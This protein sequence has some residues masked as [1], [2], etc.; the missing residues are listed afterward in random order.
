MANG[1]KRSRNQ[2]QNLQFKPGE[3]LPN[4]IQTNLKILFIGINPGLRSAATQHHFAG[5]SNRFWRF[6]AEAQLTPNLYKAEQDA[7]LLELGYG[8]TNIVPRPTAS[9]AEL[10]RTEFETGAVLLRALL[11]QYQPH[12]A[13]Y[14]GKDIYRFVARQK[15]ICWGRQLSSIIEGVIDYVIPNPSGLNRMPFQEQLNWYLELKKMIQ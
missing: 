1:T 10:S 3:T 7:Q 12:I 4:L 9:A 6:L 5:Y 8:I 11:H 14:L 2:S 13:A 15:Q